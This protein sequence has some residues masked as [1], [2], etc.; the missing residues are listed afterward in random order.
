[1]WGRRGLDAHVAKLPT[2]FI[3]VRGRG[4]WAREDGEGEAPDGQPRRFSHLSTVA[5]LSPSCLPALPDR[6]VSISRP[7]RPIREKETEFSPKSL[8]ARFRNSVPNPVQQCHER[9]ADDDQAAVA[10]PMAHRFGVQP[11]SV[12]YLR[13]TPLAG[14][15]NHSTAWVSSCEHHLNGNNQISKSA[16]V[17][18]S[19]L[20]GSFLA[21]RALRWV[22]NLIRAPRKST[23]PS[24]LIIQ[25]NP[26]L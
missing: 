24:W 20:T 12:S 18:F 22:T 3:A 21:Y 8:L 25:P 11:L 14:Q 15:S 10:F 23:G 1:M 13:I 26:G 5:P 7:H 16:P 6:A 9:D 19:P 2:K 4:K 17:L